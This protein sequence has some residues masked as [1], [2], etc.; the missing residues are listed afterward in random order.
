M[1]GFLKIDLAAGYNQVW[2]VD[3]DIPKTAFR[4]KYGAYKNVVMNFG[5]TNTPSTFVTL[6]NANFRPLIGKSV[7]IYLD[8]IIIFS[9]SKAQ[10]EL[11]LRNVI[12]ILQENQL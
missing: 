5:M 7:V 10:H 3:K 1:P 8:N 2:V 11:D 12:K 9:K 6:T 4:T